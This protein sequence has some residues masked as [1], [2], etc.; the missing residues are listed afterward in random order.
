LAGE[1]TGV[2]GYAA[3]SL[4]KVLGKVT[5]GA[6]VVPR[7]PDVVH[8]VRVMRDWLRSGEAI[9]L[10]LPRNLT[11]AACGGG[12]CDSCDRSGAITLRGRHEP[13]EIVQVTLPGLREGDSESGGDRPLTLRI[14]EQGGLPVE[15]SKL[16]RGLLLL[17]VIPADK[18]DQGVAR[19]GAALPVPA[20]PPANEPVPPPAAPRNRVTLW[21]AAAVA[22]WI[23]LLVLLR[24]SGC[25]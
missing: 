11:C 18:A 4:A 23:L 19:T 22:L 24:L 21:V 6:H 10:E 16:P 17:T 9:E 3:G 25:G 15:G 1:Q 5:T 2:P 8:R 12:G 13:P 20:A 14:P 7:G